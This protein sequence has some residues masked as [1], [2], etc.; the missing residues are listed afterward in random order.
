M[1]NS[2]LNDVYNKM[3][4]KKVIASIIQWGDKV[5][6]AQRAKKDDLYGKWEFPGGKMEPGETEIECLVR[7]LNEEFGILAEVGDYLC[8]SF[9]EHKGSLTEMRVYYVTSFIGE[10]KLYDHQEVRW[11]NIQHLLSYDMPTPDK[12]IVEK[13]LKQ[14]DK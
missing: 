12:P 5:L 13:L 1:P 9:F 8:S 4:T 14:L 3:V 2:N 7:E 11:V 10:I 6:I